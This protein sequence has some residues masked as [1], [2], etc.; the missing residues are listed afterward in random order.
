ARPKQKLEYA[1]DIGIVARGFRRV[2]R[3][4][5]GVEVIDRSV[6]LLQSEPHRQRVLRLAHLFAKRAMGQDG[7]T[8]L[9]VQYW[10]HARSNQGKPVVIVHWADVLVQPSSKFKFSNPATARV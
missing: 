8:K 7:R 4:N 10:H 3:K 6:G 1:L 9:R 2:L 5:I